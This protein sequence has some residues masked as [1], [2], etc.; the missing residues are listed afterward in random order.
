LKQVVLETE[1]DEEMQDALEAV[2]TD[3]EMK[4]VELAVEADV[5]QKVYSVLPSDAD[6]RDFQRQ[7]EQVRK[8]VRLQ[9]ERLEGSGRTRF[10]ARMRHM[11]KTAQAAGKRSERSNREGAID[12]MHG[13]LNAYMVEVAEDT[14]ELRYNKYRKL[15]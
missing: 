6:R 4:A 3:V 10:I 8:V 9:S 14:D 15:T 7:M 11:V 12:S 1:N 13:E 5:I 2:M